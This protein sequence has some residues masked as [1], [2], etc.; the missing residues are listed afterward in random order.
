MSNI[1]LMVVGFLFANN[2]VL[3]IEKGRP[4]NYKGAGRPADQVGYLN[5]VGGVVKDGET[6]V[7]CLVRKTAAETNISTVPSQWIPFHEHQ[8]GNAT[9][10]FAKAVLT[11]KQL[12]GA[13]SPTD[14]H[15]GL[16]DV[17]RI[18]NQKV[19]SN[20]HWLVAMACDE[21][22]NYSISI[23]YADFGDFTH[24]QTMSLLSTP[25]TYH[26]GGCPEDKG[27]AL[28]YVAPDYPGFIDKF[29][30]TMDAN[31]FM[32]GV[33]IVQMAVAFN[34]P[35]PTDEKMLML[36]KKVDV[37][38]PQYRI[39]SE[40]IEVIPA[41]KN[42]EGGTSEKVAETGA[43]FDEAATVGATKAEEASTPASEPAGLP[44][45]YTGQGAST[46]AAKK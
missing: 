41:E 25:M 15:V 45:A 34:V 3:L 26:G 14:E 11:P 33:E 30:S 28:T 46:K 22:H 43:P 17:D 9:I 38:A 12:S 21:K 5:G 13:C 20:I 1:K 23:G 31:G 44:S 6:A 32:S 18:F 36:L 16:F 4:A 19:L 40:G 2:Q 8:D 7:E 37:D 10:I 27:V 24:D 35:T 29:R 39:T 42:T